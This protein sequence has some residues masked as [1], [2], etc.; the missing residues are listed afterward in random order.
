MKQLHSLLLLVLA[1]IVLGACTSIECSIDNIVACQWQL[2]KSNSL[3]TL[4]TD[5]I[6]IYSTR[7]DGQDTILY[8]KGVGISAF[9]LPMSHTREADVLYLNLKDTT[10]T[11]WTDTITL[12]KT[13]QTHMESVDCSPQYFHTL[14]GIKYTT[15]IIDSIVINNSNVNND[16][17]IQHLYLYLRS[18]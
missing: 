12:S 16:A 9:S 18:H 2:R 8:N 17:T 15:N 14:T 5:T 1:V 4:K 7:A 3:D 13:N 11:E 6:T 10:Q